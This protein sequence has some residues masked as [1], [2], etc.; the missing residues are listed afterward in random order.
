MERPRAEL[1]QR[2]FPLVACCNQFIPL[3]QIGGTRDAG[4]FGWENLSWIGSPAY[5]IFGSAAGILPANQSSSMSAETAERQTRAR[6]KTRDREQS[7]SWPSWSLL[8]FSG[9]NFPEHRVAAC[10]SSLRVV[11]AYLVGDVERD[12]LSQRVPDGAVFVP[13]QGDRTLYG[14][15]RTSP[16][17][18]K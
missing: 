13:G 5:A 8:A 10:A 18:A 1:L 2:H 15:G 7:S 11:L 9:R 16:L 12:V 6:H 3:R 4:G 14:V 17:I